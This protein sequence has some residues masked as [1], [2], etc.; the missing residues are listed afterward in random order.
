MKTTI[1]VIGLLLGVSSAMKLHSL[2]HQQDDELSAIDAAIN[3]AEKTG[4]PEAAPEQKEETPAPPKPEPVE[5][6]QEDLPKKDEVES[7]MDKYDHDEEHEAFIKTDAYKVQ[8]EKAKKAKE[9]SKHTAANE[10]L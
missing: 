5:L 6:P 7:L 4:E 8:V 2:Q 9:A 3:A 1:L 10:E